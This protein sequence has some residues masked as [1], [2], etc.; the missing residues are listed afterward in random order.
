MTTQAALLTRLRRYIDDLGHGYSQS[1]PGFVTDLRDLDPDARV[2]VQIDNDL[3]PV[4]V[5]LGATSFLSAGPAIA[6]ALQAAIRAA[7]PSLPLAKTPGWAYLTVTFDQRDGYVLRSGTRGT[8]S[9]VRILP[10]L[11]ND[12]AVLLKLGQSQGGYETSP[13][14]DFTDEDLSQILDSALEEQNASGIPSAWTYQTLP[15]NCELLVLYR[16][17]AQVVDVRLGQTAMEHWQ[18]VESEEQ[19]GD[20]I[21]A[22]YFKLADW[23]KKRIAAMEEA[24]GGSILVT[25]TS[26]WDQE[27]GMMVHP[28]IVKD[29]SLNPAIL[30]VSWLDAS[31]ALLEFRE[32]ASTS[33]N[34]LH[35]GYK[36]QGLGV[37]DRSVFTQEHGDVNDTKGFVSPSVKF[38]TL[39][40]GRETLV[41][42]TGLDNTKATSFAMLVEDAAGNHYY[43]NEVTLAAQ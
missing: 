12:C 9:R 5:S 33:F 6:A 39:Y 28:G 3:A 26:R 41:R 13:A 20:Q 23:L 31:T 27:A 19:H 17:W 16:A 18:K 36:I 37:I 35:I 7:D 42:V 11:T 2:Q 1:A 22:N 21:F 30:A 25:S 40:S 34:C 15:S 32:I 29:T 43:S 38:R 14:L 8:N 24:L 4:E 10:A